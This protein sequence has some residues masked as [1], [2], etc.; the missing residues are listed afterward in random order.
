MGAFLSGRFFYPERSERAM[1]AFYL[2]GFFIPGQPPKQA[3][4]YYYYRE[5]FEEEEEE[6]DEDRRSFDA[7]L[8][9]VRCRSR[10]CGLGCA[11]SGGAPRSLLVA[12]Q[13]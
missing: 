9:F 7:A 3:H 6:E 13:F 11:H 5:R 8:T 2:V 10:A 1:V 12:M 4:Y